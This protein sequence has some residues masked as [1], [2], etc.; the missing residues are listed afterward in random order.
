MFYPLYFYPHIFASIF[1]P[2]HLSFYFYSYI[3]I[4]TLYC[5][6]FVISVSSI[7]FYYKCDICSTIP[8]VS[9]NINTGKCVS[10]GLICYIA[11][12]DRSTDVMTEGEGS[13]EGREDKEGGQ[14]VEDKQKYNIF[15]FFSGM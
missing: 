6:D 1:L 4:L 10:G 9:K 8:S 5:Y 14:G 7:D 13:K 3:A 2:L 11:G 15:Y 12:G